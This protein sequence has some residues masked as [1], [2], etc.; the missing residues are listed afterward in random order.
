MSIQHALPLLLHHL[1]SAG[2]G[3][4]RVHVRL[5]RHSWKEVTSFPT[6]GTTSRLTGQCDN[7][8]R[9]F[10][11]SLTAGRYAPRPVTGTVSVTKPFYIEERVFEGVEGLEVDNPFLERNYVQCASL[12]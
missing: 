5:T 7:F 12:G 9:F 11:T 10:N 8:I 1:P 3:D 6:F 2:L 4:W